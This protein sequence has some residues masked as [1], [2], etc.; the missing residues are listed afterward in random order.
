M[1][2]TSMGILIVI[3]LLTAAAPGF[4]WRVFPLV[5]YS[6]T[7][8]FLFGG[9]AS[10]N[11]MPPFRPFA[12]STMAYMYTGG[13]LYAGPELLFPAGPGMVRIRAEYSVNKSKKFYGWGNGGDGDVYAEY[14]SENQEL[15]CS[16]NYTPSFSLM[17]TGGGRLLHS[18]AYGRQDSP[19]WSSSPSE[20]YGSIWTAGPYVHLRAAFPSFLEGYTSLDLDH[21]FGGDHSYSKAELALAC[22]TPITPYS[23]PA[24]RLGISRHFS[25]ASTPF[26]LL[27]S[28]GGSE[29]LRGYSDG[30]FRGDWS[31]L[32]NLEFR[33]RIFSLRLD[34][35]VSM[36]FGIVAFGD[37]GQTADDLSELR[38]DG[39]HLDAGLGARVGIPGGATLRADFA[40]SPE[41]LGIQIGLGQ[42]F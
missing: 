10:H 9:V 7:N 30:R 28:L 26:Q 41:G 8:G 31:V 13:S 23:I 11:M 25:S 12:F 4:C 29:G 37:A 22:F 24:L 21:Q 16:Y 38:W 19:L 34:E 6:S 18:T 20:A 5:S 3:L 35:E 17:L 36:D 39:F 15:S 27:P 1:M 33:Q 14:E 40:L 32:A 2:R 42:L